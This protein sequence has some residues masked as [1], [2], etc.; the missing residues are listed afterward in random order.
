MRGMMARCP[1]MLT[2]CV[3]SKEP[4]VRANE[5]YTYAKSSYARNDGM[6]SS[7]VNSLR[8]YRAHL[9]VRMALSSVR[10]EFTRKE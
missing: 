4:Y 8:M 1:C 5:P 2:L 7:H 9:S 10:T 6:L 3:H